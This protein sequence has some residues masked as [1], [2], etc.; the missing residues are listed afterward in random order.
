MSI[1]AEV[2]FLSEGALSGHAGPNEVEL[3]DPWAEDF[4]RQQCFP[5]VRPLEV[6]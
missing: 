2:A 1:L 5:G 6:A 4:V 3:S